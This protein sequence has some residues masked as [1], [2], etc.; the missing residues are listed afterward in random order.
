MNVKKTKPIYIGADHGG[1]EHKEYIRRLLEKKG[2]PYVDIGTFD[3]K[4]V[5]YPK[6]AKEVAKKAVKEDTLG[7]LVCG[8]GTGM[9]I[10]ANKIKGARAAVVYDEY[11]A[12]MARK[13]NDAQI[14]CLRGRNFPK[15][16]IKIIVESFLST[17]PSKAKRHV[18]R[19]EEASR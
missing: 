10:A 16:K 8:T 7:F 2:V 17:K 14:A 19:R 1:F 12:T 11:S 4:P 5:D 3:E 6:Y 9:C 13:D 15:T 18:R